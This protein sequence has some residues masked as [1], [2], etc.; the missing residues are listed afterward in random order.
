[1]DQ[2]INPSIYFGATQPY[3]DHVV[4][5]NA[6][7]LTDRIWRATYDITSLIP[8]GTYTVTVSGATG[9]DGM[10]IATD[11]RFS[12]VV[13]YAGQITDQ[14]PP[15]APWVLASGKQSDASYVEATW[16]ASDP[17]SSIT[18]YR[19]AIGSAA[20]ATDVVSWTT[21]SAKG[22]S[23]SGLGLIAGRQYWVAVQAQNTGGLWSA[24]AY[25]SFTAGQALRQA[26]LPLVLR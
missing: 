2:S 14:T 7:W 18:G 21:T 17:E 23:R 4:Y 10:E 15:G 9:L 8:R 6:Q 16:S 22:V 24:S 11:T 12:L 5:E 25:S 20:G 1:M 19:Y 3:T 26:Y 13:N